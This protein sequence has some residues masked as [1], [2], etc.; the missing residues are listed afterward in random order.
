MKMN[1]A[2]IRYKFLESRPWLIGTSPR[3]ILGK[4]LID[5]AVSA[6]IS[7]GLFYISKYKYQTKISNKLNLKEA[8]Y[9]LV[10]CW[11]FM[12]Q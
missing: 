11:I 2:L 5:Q 7:T 12:F 10:H 8:M 9:V 1:V 4:V 3:A 6:S